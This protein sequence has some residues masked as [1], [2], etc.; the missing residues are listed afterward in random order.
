MSKYDKLRNL[1]DDD[2][3]LFNLSAQKT[4]GKILDVYDG[5]RCRIVMGLD[6]IIVKFNCKL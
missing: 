5:E 4:I 1:T 2:I 6:A 3:D